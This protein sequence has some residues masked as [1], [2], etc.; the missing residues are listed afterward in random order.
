MG[1]FDKAIKDG[2]IRTVNN[3][4]SN[5]VKRK[6]TETAEPAINKAVNKAADAVI[7][8]AQPPQ[9]QGRGQQAA[10]TNGAQLGGMFSAFT[11]G[12]QSFADEAAKNMKICPSCGG[13]ANADTKYCPKCG[14]ELPAQTIAQGVVCEKCGK[15]NSV[16]VKFCSDCGAKLPAAVAEEQAAK[17]KD[18]AVLAKWETVLPQYPKWCF[19]GHNLVLETVTEN[20]SGP[21]CYVFYASGAGSAEVDQYRLLLKQNGFRTAGQYPDESQ[22]YKRVDN[23][24]YNADIEHAFEADGRISLYLMAREPSGG[25]DYVKPEPK[26]PSGLKGLFGFMA[27]LAMWI[28]AG[29]H[30]Q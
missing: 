11:G 21:P 1:I 18:E 19:G 3:T 22:L 28:L 17:A 6:V 20:Y 5:T 26:K 16:G 23:T 8:K 24:V 29:S 30:G 2:L 15:Q 4:V 10:Q 25:V 14:A 9:G 13:A 27:V 12:M 7:P